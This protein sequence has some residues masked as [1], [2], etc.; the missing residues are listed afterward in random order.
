MVITIRCKL[1]K[2]HLTNNTYILYIFELKIFSC[3]KALQLFYG[4]RQRFNSSS[5]SSKGGK[6]S[7]GARAPIN[8]RYY[9]NCPVLESYFLCSAVVG[10][11]INVK[12]GVMEKGLAGRKRLVL[13]ACNILGLCLR[14][15]LFQ[16]KKLRAERYNQIL[17]DGVPKF[18]YLK[19]NKVPTLYLLEKRTKTKMW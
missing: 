4:F 6:Q 16:W 18:L 5:S 1:N 3:I 19:S 10:S 2:I 9:A 7:E 14:R 8:C 15:N 11:L 13:R 17:S 12:K